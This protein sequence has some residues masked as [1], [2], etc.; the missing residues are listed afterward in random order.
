MLRRYATFAQI[1]SPV[2]FRPS[3]IHDLQKRPPEKGPTIQIGVIVAPDMHPFEALLLHSPGQG[4]T[5][6]QIRAMSFR[7]TH[8]IVPCLG[9]MRGCHVMVRFASAVRTIRSSRI[10]LNLMMY[11]ENILVTVTRLLECLIFR[12]LGIASFD[13]SKFGRF[14]L[15]KYLGYFQIG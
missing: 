12:P 15:V 2:A 4:P 3:S 1:D 7:T 13:V 6:L 11:Q 9:S 10:E 5:L 8:E 14:V